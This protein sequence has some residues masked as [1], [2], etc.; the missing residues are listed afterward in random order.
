MGGFCTCADGDKT[1]VGQFDQ[2]VIGAEDTDQ[3]GETFDKL[4]MKTQTQIWVNK[5]EVRLAYNL[6]RKKPK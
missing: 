5:N 6:R 1:R 4:L 3:G 2:I